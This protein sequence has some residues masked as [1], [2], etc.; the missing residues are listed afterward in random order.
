MYAMSSRR[1]P[2]QAAQEPA[3]LRSFVSTC[4]PHVPIV[5]SSTRS[6]AG[7]ALQDHSHRGAAA[8]SNPSS[9]PRAVNHAFAGLALFR[10]SFARAGCKIQGW[11]RV[12]CC[13]SPSSRYQLVTRTKFGDNP[14]R[15]SHS[16][17]FGDA[18]RGYAEKG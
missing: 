18:R 16:H 12:N 5:A 11:N 9:K 7:I 17:S 10:A 13:P 8:A 6:P 2:H 15:H 14:F 1:E 4:P 3:R